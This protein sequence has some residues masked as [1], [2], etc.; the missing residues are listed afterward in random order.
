M[1]QGAAAAGDGARLGHFTDQQF[2]HKRADPRDG[3]EEGAMRVSDTSVTIDDRR[4]SLPMA[5]VILSSKVL[6]RLSIR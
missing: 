1:P 6:I 4:S 2:A 3:E 5:R